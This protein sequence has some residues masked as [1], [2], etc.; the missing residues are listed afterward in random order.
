M[1]GG[2]K[3]QRESPNTEVQNTN[4]TSHESCKKE[5]RNLRKYAVAS[6][7][8]NPCRRAPFYRET[9]GLSTKFPNINQTFNFL[10]KLI[11]LD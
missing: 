4:H 3:N 10:V 1:L 2:P 8:V 11:W 6:K 5:T 9:K 7:V